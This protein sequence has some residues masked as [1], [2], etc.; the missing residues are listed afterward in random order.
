MSRW[1]IIPLKGH[2]SEISQRVGT[3]SVEILSVTNNAGFV[4]S[5][6]VF[7]KQV[8]S[9]DMSNY[10]LVKHNDIAYNPSRINVGSVA[11]CGLSGGGAVSPMYIVVR[12]R[13]SLLSH[14]LL[15]YLRS[16]T[17]RQHIAHRCVGAV[18]FQL[19]YTDLEQLEIPLPPPDEQARIVRI[20]DEADQLRRLRSEAD[21]RTFNLTSALF[22]QMF[23]DP[24]TNPRNWPSGVLGDVIHAAKDG[25]HVSPE[26]TEDEDGVPFISTRNISPGRIIWEDMKF[27]S[28]AEAIKHWKKCKPE[29]GDVLY[30]KGGTTGMA[31][32]ID[33]IKDIAVW[34]HVAVLKTNHDKVDPVWLES[35]LNSRFCYDQSQQLTHGIANRDLGLT[36]MIDIRTYIPP[37]PL[38]QEYG[39]CVAKVQKLEIEQIKCRRRLDDLFQSLLHRSFQG[40]L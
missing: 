25:P 24:S 39:M 36:R 3:S 13:E 8:F 38:Q 6:D 7:D 11:R 4:R 29:F 22:H 31:K 21:R 32:A 27:I 5:L 2:I 12:C 28:R 33:F 37:L 16:D 14:Y 1:P 10:K 35:M 19:R 9:E 34:V 40:E 17:G 18:R 26:Y 30:T 20:L 15:Y 23:G